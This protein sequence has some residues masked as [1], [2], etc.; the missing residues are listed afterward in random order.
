MHWFVFYSYLFVAYYQ[1]TFKNARITFLFS[2]MHLLAKLY[3]SLFNNCSTFI[4]KYAIE[5]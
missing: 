3:F 1:V 2:I 5:Y 4:E